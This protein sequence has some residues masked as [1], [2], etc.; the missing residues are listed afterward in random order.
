VETGSVPG[1]A[2]AALLAHAE[3]APAASACVASTG[4]CVTLFVTGSMRETV[5]S[6]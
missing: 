3:P 6:T 2:P 4:T 1:L 5:P